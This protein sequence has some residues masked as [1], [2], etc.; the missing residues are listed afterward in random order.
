[1]LTGPRRQPPHSP[2]TATRVS[3]NQLDLCVS[4][5]IA[6]DSRSEGRSMQVYN[7]SFGEPLDAVMFQARIYDPN[8]PNICTNLN[9]IIN[10]RVT[11]LLEVPEYQTNRLF[12]RSD[13]LVLR[14]K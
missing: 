12:E 2:P 5:R 8:Q 7:C 9:A 3:H 11:M 1:M 4:N 14:R 13:D 6:S 10:P